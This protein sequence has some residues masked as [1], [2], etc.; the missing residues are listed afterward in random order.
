MERSLREQVAVVTGGGSGIGRAIASRF[1]RMG[2]SVAIWDI[3]AN[4]SEQVAKE[5][6]G[7]GGSALN[8]QVDVADYGA[9]LKAFKQTREAFGKI[10][11]LVSNA[12]NTTPPTLLTRLSNEDW[13]KVIAV[14]IN[15]AF[16]CIKAIAPSM[17]EQKYGRI[18]IMSS[19]AALVDLSGQANYATAKAGLVGLTLSASTELGP[20]GITVNAVAPGLIRTAITRDMLSHFESHL[21]QQ[22]PVGRIGE[23]A[24]VANLVAFLASPESAFVTGSVFR[25]DGGNVI[26]TGLHQIMSSLLFGGQSV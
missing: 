1:G 9:V 7:T 13:S 25:I 4:S 2:V 23:P 15:G 8:I 24:D 18:I 16:Y 26:F 5:I 12:G 3:D 11:V 6:E 21:A 14:H 20:F 17:I 19:V 22:I 10:D